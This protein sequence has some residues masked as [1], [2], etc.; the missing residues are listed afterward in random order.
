MKLPAIW[1]AI[2]ER[3]EHQLDTFSLIWIELLNGPNEV[4]EFFNGMVYPF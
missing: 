4:K 1:A 2:K 3:A